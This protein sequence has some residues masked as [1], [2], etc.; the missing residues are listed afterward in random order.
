[1]I[2][3]FSLSYVPQNHRKNIPVFL[4][5][6]GWTE[7]KGN[8]NRSTGVNFIKEL[9]RVIFAIQTTHV[10]FAIQTKKA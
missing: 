5:H 9:T 10:I 2:C 8:G 3:V 1:M 7:K 4:S 6:L